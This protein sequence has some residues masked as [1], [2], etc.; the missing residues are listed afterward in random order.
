MMKSERLLSQWEGTFVVLESNRRRSSALL[1][2][3]AHTSRLTRWIVGLT[4]AA[5]LTVLLVAVRSVDPVQNWPH[6]L[7][8]AVDAGIYG[9][10]RSDDAAAGSPATGR[11]VTSVPVESG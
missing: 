9:P 6:A 4:V 7:E 2:E 1:Q 5:M 3:A 10:A 8:D 11:A